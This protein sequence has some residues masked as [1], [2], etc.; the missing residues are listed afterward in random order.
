M[1]N[2]VLLPLRSG[3]RGSRLVMDGAACL[4]DV[5]SGGCLIWTAS[6]HRPAHAMHVRCLSTL[7]N[8]GRSQAGCGADKECQQAERRDET[9]ERGLH[10]V[11]IE[12]DSSRIRYTTVLFYRELR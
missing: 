9:G 7:N 10:A 11:S 12:T 5:R 6:M 4:G 8:H 3:G 2:A 1:W